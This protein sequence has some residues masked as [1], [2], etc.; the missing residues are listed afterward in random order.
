ME[1]DMDNHFEIFN[2]LF[3]KQHVDDEDIKKQ[4]AYEKARHGDR[5]GQGLGARQVNYSPIRTR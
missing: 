3:T 5:G 2:T 1:K 4:E